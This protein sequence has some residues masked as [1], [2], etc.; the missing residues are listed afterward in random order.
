MKKIICFLGTDGAGKSTLIKETLNYFKSQNKTVK[1]IYFGWKPFLPTTKFL[2][3][4]LERKNVQT[5]TKLN[6][7][8]KSKLRIPMMI[9]FYLEYLARY[10][11]QVK[12]SKEKI[13]LLDRYFYDLFAH[14]DFTSNN[15]FAHFLLKIYPKPT[16]LFFLD[17]NPNIAKKRKPE[18]NTELIKLHRSRYLNL[19]NK[20][21]FNLINTNKPIEECIEEIS[22]IIKK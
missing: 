8:S 6:H 17:I 13:I 10:T 7:K 1:S 22:S 9:Y 15:K 2:S 11:F 20:L 3:K 5:T 19:G 18:V 12:F 21:K 14:Y 4:F 16:K